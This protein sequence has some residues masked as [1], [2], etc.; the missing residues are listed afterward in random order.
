M[1]RAAETEGESQASS[2]DRG[3]VRTTAPAKDNGTL[4]VSVASGRHVDSIHL[5]WLL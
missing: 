4:H 2:A 5:P 3:Q 1:V